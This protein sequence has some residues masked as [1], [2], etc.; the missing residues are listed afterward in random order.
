MD[1]ARVILWSAPR[2][3]STAFE[4]SIRELETV[5]VIHEPLWAAYHDIGCKRLVTH[6]GEAASPATY[7]TDARCT[8]LQPYGG[9]EAVF[10]KLICSH[11]GG[12]YER[13]VEGEFSEYKHTFLIRHPTKALP[14]GYKGCVECHY[15]YSAWISGFPALYEMYNFVKQKVDPSPIVVDADDLLNDPKGTM[16]KYCTAT[17]LP[18]KETMVSWEPKSFPEW[19]S[20][21]FSQVWYGSAMKSSGFMK[22][23]TSSPPSTKDLPK[24]VIA[25]IEEFIPQYETL[26][27]TRI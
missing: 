10:Y 24:D 27:S 4:R 11:T 8:M 1:Q 12:Q 9:Y 13:F 25:L 18:F 2:C 20:D 7:G 3:L 22:P 26:H 15:T 17:G 16:K 14:S 5:K 21:P 19:D 23:S 6:P